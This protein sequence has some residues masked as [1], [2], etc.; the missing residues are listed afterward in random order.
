MIPSFVRAALL[1]PDPLTSTPT[2]SHHE[3][4]ATAAWPVA[5]RASVI[6]AGWTAIVVTVVLL[7]TSAEVL[8]DQTRPFLVLGA[9]VGAVSG[10]LGNI[11]VAQGSLRRVG[12]PQAS[13][14]FVRAIVLD[15][16][17]QVVAVVGGTVAVRFFLVLKFQDFATFG[18][19]LAGAVVLF[20]VPGT[21]LVNRALGLRARRTGGIAT[22]ATGAKESN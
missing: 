8:P 3:H 22:A 1:V 17:V 13:A 18:M 12:G 5:S 7:A 21:I 19:T 10:T 2:E 20:R 9:I 11:I 4:P 14:E 16:A 15:F 6:G